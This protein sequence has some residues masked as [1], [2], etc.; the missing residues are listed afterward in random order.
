MLL[1]PLQIPCASAQETGS[2]GA[3]LA[4]R[5]VGSWELVSYKV[6]DKETGQLIDAMGSTPRGRAIF[7]RDGWVAF[8]LEGSNRQPATSDAERA[9]L[10]KSLVAYIGL[11]RI[12]GDA[13]VTAVETAWAPEWVGTEQRR[14][15]RMDGD[16]ADVTTPWRVMPNW[17]GGRPSRSH[18]RF[19]RVS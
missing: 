1:T 15:I 7:T 17:G 12:E 4:D 9:E 5:I 13:W 3:S 10:M 16:Y 11:Y 2:S 19:K 8:N 6:E 18:V 14:A